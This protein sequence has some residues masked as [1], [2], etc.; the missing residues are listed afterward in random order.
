MSSGVLPYQDN[1][2]EVV[3]DLRDWRVPMRQGPEDLVALWEQLEPSLRG[4]SLRTGKVHSWDAD[5][6]TISVEIMRVVPGLST[7]QA[8]TRFGLVAVREAPRLVYRCS[9][10]DKQ[11]R[12]EY[13]PFRC[14]S[15][16]QAGQQSRVCVQHVV[17]LNGS[18]EASCPSHRPTCRACAAPAAFW[19]AGPKG[20]LSK[21]AWCGRHGS[22]H[23][24]DVDTHYCLDCYRETFP[25]CE[26]RG[27]SAV[28]TVRC[29]WLGADHRSCGRRACTRHA[30]RWQVFGAE[31]VGIG[32]CAEHSG[33]KSLT[34]DRILNQ[35][36]GAAARR[37]DVR[38]PSLAAF[39]HNLRNCGHRELALDF[40]R[41][42]AALRTLET[43]L[44][45]RGLA[46]AL[47]AVERADPDWDK[48]LDRLGGDAVEGERIVERLRRLVRESD[49]GFGDRIAA[50]LRLSQYKPARANGRAPARAAVLWVHVPD[51][52]RGK[53]IGPQGS[54]ITFYKNTLGID[55]NI[56]DGGRR[57]QR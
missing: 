6:G 28:G 42:R 37:T 25:V 53:F 12:A 32:L 1:D 17:V 44:R 21:V 27:C 10:C 13:G 56:E 38:T 34:A 45:R 33:I 51:D 52:L 14:K 31:K 7:A 4:T 26:E 16:E 39:G 20:C 5:H 47:R 15:C 41:I 18:L 19:C 30:R 22:Q 29:D 49:R 2:V 36:C 9:V 48:E 23:P 46:E 3:L 11:G 8:G 55:I 40:T 43:D 57:A 50:G 24:Q 35:I 54:R